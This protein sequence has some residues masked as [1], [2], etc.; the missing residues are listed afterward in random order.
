MPMRWFEIDP[1]DTLFFRGAEPMEPGETHVQSLE[2]PP[3]PQTL[4][5][6]VRTATLSRAGVTFAPGWQGRL[7]EE[8]RT[9]IGADPEPPATFSLFGPLFAYGGAPLYP[10]PA[11]WRSDTAGRV[12]RLTPVDRN[13]ADCWGIRHVAGSVS[14]PW[15]RNEVGKDGTIRGWVTAEGLAAG[16]RGD[17]L[18]LVSG[19]D[20]SPSE[21]IPTDIVIDPDAVFDTESRVGLA[22]D[23]R[24]AKE[25]H[26]YS[27]SHIRLRSGVTMVFGL[28]GVPTSVLPG[29]GLLQWG[30]EQR[31]VCYRERG[32]VAVPRAESGSRWMAV[33]PIPAEKVDQGSRTLRLDGAAVPLRTWVTEKFRKVGGWDLAKREHKPLQSWFPAGTVLYPVEPPTTQRIQLAE[34]QG[35]LWV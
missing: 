3:L 4:I 13:V 34:R 19:K 20:L 29:S 33:V 17:Q 5:G 31:L 10:V 23:G 9:T 12:V 35:L 18:R 14:L 7:S 32:P 2:F 27:T 6:A 28:D 21:A 11:D 24:R 25:G 16:D 15:L 22:L 26:L 8:V 30:G 1:L